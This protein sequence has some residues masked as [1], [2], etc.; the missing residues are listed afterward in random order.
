MYK[1]KTYNKISIK[2]SNFHTFAT[3][4]LEYC[5]RSDRCLFF[6]FAMV[7]IF[8]IVTVLLDV[9]FRWLSVGFF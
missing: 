7:G 5:K 8:L 4:Q 6:P 1:I 3:L 2:G 9:S